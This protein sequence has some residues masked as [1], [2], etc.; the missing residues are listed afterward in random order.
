MLGLK[1]SVSPGIASAAFSRRQPALADLGHPPDLSPLYAEPSCKSQSS[2]LAQFS[3]P[4]QILQ[5]HKFLPA[6][7]V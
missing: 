5:Q 1:Q 6:R 4:F 3:I 7:H 2:T